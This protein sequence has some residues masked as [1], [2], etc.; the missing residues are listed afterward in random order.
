MK[1]RFRSVQLAV[2]GL[3]R[4]QER[5]KCSLKGR[6]LRGQHFQPCSQVLEIFELLKDVQHEGK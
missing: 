6:K 5:G 2:C 3:C 1:G 4:Y